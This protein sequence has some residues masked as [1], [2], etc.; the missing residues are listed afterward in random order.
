MQITKIKRDPA[1]G[2]TLIRWDDTPDL[3]D[4]ETLGAP[5]RAQALDRHELASEDEPHPD[6]DEA[7]TA[8]DLAFVDVCELDTHWVD[9]CTVRGLTITYNAD[10]DMRAMVTATRKVSA[11]ELVMVVNTPLFEPSGVLVRF[12]ETACQ[13]ARRYVRGKRAQAGLFDG[14]ASGDGQTGGIDSMTISDRTGRSIT[15]TRKGMENLS[16]GLSRELD[17]A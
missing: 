15:L 14:D 5:I 11:E 16:G 1:K 12:V 8:L 6:F 17:E 13:E 10:G 2:T 9:G 4:D 3:L 7:L